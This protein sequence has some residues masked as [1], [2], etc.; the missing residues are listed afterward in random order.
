MFANL[1]C[2]ALLS[3]A[4]HSIMARQIPHES[5]IDIVA[6][7]PLMLPAFSMLCPGYSRR[8]KYH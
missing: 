5:I 1:D 2:C 4:E 8:E 3:D 6:V 7:G